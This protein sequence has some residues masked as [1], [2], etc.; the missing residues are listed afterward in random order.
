MSSQEARTASQMAMA[1][2]VEAHGDTRR[3]S[4][5]LYINH[6]RRVA[7]M[8]AA[9]GHDDDTVAAGWL[10]DTVEDTWVTLDLL[11][12]LGFSADVINAVESVTHRPGEW[13]FDSIRRAAAHS[14]GCVV[15]L[16]DNQDNSAWEP[17]SSERF[18]KRQQ[19]IRKYAKARTLLW[20]A[21]L[22]CDSATRLPYAQ[23]RSWFSRP[24]VAA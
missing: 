8:L 1:L 3:F 15:K 11:R 21:V 18:R 6:P 5:E 2:A 24:A 17:S 7:E 13:Y 19:Q 12:T 23:P 14:I 4:G 16:A 20:E 22:G 9:A 10:H